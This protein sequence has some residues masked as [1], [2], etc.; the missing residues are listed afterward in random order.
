MLEKIMQF[1]SQILI[2]MLCIFVAFAILDSLWLVVIA[3]QWYQSAMQGMLREVLITCAWL[4]FN[5]SYGF[6]TF[7]LATVPIL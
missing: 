5:L 4:I 2:S 7:V 1:L 3:P 6:V